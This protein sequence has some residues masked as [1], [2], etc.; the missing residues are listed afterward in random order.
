MKIGYKHN[1]GVFGSDAEAYVSRLFVMM[2]N[3]QGSR[4]PDLISKN[5]MYNPRLSIEVKSGR[6]KKGILVDYQLHYAVTSYRDYMQLSG[7]EPRELLEGVDWASSLPK[8]DVAY[9]YDIIDR[10][11]ELTSIDVNGEHS[12][13]KIKWGDQFIIPHQYGFYAFAVA[14]HMRTNEPLDRIV[15]DLSNVIKEDVFAINSGYTNRK[16]DKQSWQD[17]HGRDVLAI[18]Q[19]DLAYATK[20]GRERI[21][22]IGDLY[23]LSKL[24]RVVISGP[25]KTDIYVLSEPTHFDLFDNQLRGTVAERI[26]AIERITRQ[27]KH[28]LRL[29]VP[30]G[31][32]ENQLFADQ[33]ITYRNKDL[34]PLQQ[35]RLGA[36]SEWRS[37]DS[38][39]NHVITDDVPV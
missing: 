6:A 32:D 38:A 34:S 15:N 11:D 14:R 3:H 28:A 16:K 8:I 23:D 22:H 33:P 36:L 4:R 26:D 21:R 30:R 7:E 10:K 9:Y 18:F 35:Q 12:N 31:E 1:T 19:D 29:I 20:D 5:G 39:D 27:R 2:R 24:K 37:L 13:I 25:N 17:I